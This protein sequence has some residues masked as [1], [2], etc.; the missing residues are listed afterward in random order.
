MSAKLFIP[1]FT[2]TCGSDLVDWAD[3]LEDLLASLEGIHESGLEDVAVWHHGRLVA[4]WLH[5]GSRIDLAA[6]FGA[7]TAQD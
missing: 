6:L 2:A 1:P 5:D 7:P 4:L 3:T